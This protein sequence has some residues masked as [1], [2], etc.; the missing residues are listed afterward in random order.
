M[1]GGNR[2]A[3]ALTANFTFSGG[4][5]SVADLVGS[6]NADGKVGGTV[7]F[8]A[9]DAERLAGSALGA[10]ARGVGQALGQALGGTPLSGLARGV[11]DI[12]AAIAVASERFAGKAGPMSG[13]IT[14]RSGQLSTNNLRVDGDRAWAITVAAANLATWTQDV[15]VNLFVQEDPTKPYVVVKQTGSVEHPARSIA[16]GGAQLP[17][18]RPQ[19][20]QP[21]QPS[22]TT[23][24]PSAPPRPAGPVQG[25]Q[26]LLKG[27]GRR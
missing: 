25:V 11:D 22:P 17:Q 18:E 7:R 20:Q 9:T 10:G 5:A 26:D 3:G 15:T 1:V 19:Q 13:D 23:Q 24:Q 16:R 8:V 2:V 14:I 4:L 6:L 21:Q 12:G 27:L